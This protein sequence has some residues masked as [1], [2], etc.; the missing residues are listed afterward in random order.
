MEETKPYKP[1]YNVMPEVS[2][3]D[4]RLKSSVVSKSTILKS[5]S[6]IT[7]NAINND[8]ASPNK[9]WRLKRWIIITSGVLLLVLALV[10][11]L[12]FTLRS[13]NSNVAQNSNQEE[14]ITSIPEVTT[15][16]EWLARYFGSEI[17][18][19]LVLCGDKADP[20]RDGLDNLAEY[21]AG[22]DPNNPDTDG[23][24]LADG[25]EVNVFSTDPLLTR[26]YR[27]GPYT[28]LDFARGGY[29]IATNEPYT[30]ERLLE[31]KSKIKQFGLHQPTLS[32]LG[33]ISFELYEFIDLNQP[34]LPADL[35]LSPQAKLDRDSQRQSTTKKIGAALLRYFDEKKSFPPT[36]DFIVM[37]DL[38][39][40]YNMVA[41]NYN[42]PIDI[43]PYKYGYQSQNNNQEFVL[44]YYSETQSQLIKYTSKNARDDAVKENTQA[45]DD[46]RKLDI[47]TIQRAL[48]VWSSIQLDPASEKDFVFPP[49]D[50]LKDELVP[51]YLTA[52]PND[53][54]SKQGYVYEVGPTFDTFTIRAALQNPVAGT[55]GYMCNQSECRNY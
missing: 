44:S 4:P 3:D 53:P 1:F 36:D 10:V 8:L 54:V 48:L 16:P 9:P 42:D 18:T 34:A 31:I 51:R 29:D 7:K 14:Q 15:P 24:G 13:D 52:L 17:C 35:D 50:K 41:T 6:Q 45:I 25:D 37:A 39:R 49:S 5:S 22:T 32:S 30:N 11:I 33:S 46:Q 26:T 19:E 47:E 23:D 43:S 2:G 20:D 21:N 27:D 40:A 12:Y 38:I 28:D 55:T